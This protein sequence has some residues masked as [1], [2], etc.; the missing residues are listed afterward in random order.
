MN[1]YA[2]AASLLVLATNIAAFAPPALNT[3]A[4]PALAMYGEL[5][6][7]EDADACMEALDIYEVDIFSGCDPLGEGYPFCYSDAIETSME[8]FVKRYDH[9]AREKAKQDK[10]DA[11]VVFLESF[12][13]KMKLDLFEHCV[14]HEDKLERAEMLV[15]HMSMD[16]NDQW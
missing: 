4:S 2:K 14:T 10:L 1:L 11:R 5:I 16:E 8:R 7:E 3:R 12:A 9:G 15:A 6:S 13:Q